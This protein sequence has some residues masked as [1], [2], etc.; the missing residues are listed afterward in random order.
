M[1]ARMA[2]RSSW[3]VGARVVRMA[4]MPTL[5]AGASVALMY[6]G[7]AQHD[8]HH[9]QQRGLAGEAAMSELSA[10]IKKVREAHGASTWP[11]VSW[12]MLPDS[13]IDVWWHHGSD[14]DCGDVL[15]RLLTDLG[16]RMTAEAA[17]VDTQVDKY[18]TVLVPSVDRQSQGKC[19]ARAE[20]QRAVSQH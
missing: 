17:Y 15:A 8:H 11:K 16:G 7:W 14:V 12:R 3:P 20:V 2:M 5:G 1:W 6:D 4:A 13:V 18:E 9:Q 19:Q 10:R